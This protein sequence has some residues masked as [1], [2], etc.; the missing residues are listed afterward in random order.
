MSS[1][2]PNSYTFIHSLKK[3]GRRAC[4]VKVKLPE[5]TVNNRNDTDM[6]KYD[7]YATRK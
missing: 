3:E 4:S 1:L 7:V 6:D 2:P 5:L